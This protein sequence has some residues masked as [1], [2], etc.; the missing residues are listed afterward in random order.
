[1]P[2]KEKQPTYKDVPENKAYPEYPER[3]Y[4]E[5]VRK[6]NAEAERSAQGLPPEE[7]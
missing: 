4:E 6:D 2:D 7:K 3:P 1:M 5:A